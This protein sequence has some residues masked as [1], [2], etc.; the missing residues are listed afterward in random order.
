MAANLRTRHYD[1]AIILDDIAHVAERPLRRSSQRLNTFLLKTAAAEFLAVAGSAYVASAIY[2]FTTSLSLPPTDTYIAAAVSIATLVFMVSIALRQFI[3]IQSQPRHVVLWNG[4]VSV[5]LAFSLFLSCIFLLKLSDDYSRGSFLFQIAAVGIVVVTGRAISLS[6][7]RSAISTRNFEA[8][9]VVLIGETGMNLQFIG[10]LEEIGIKTVGSFSLP[11][12][13]DRRGGGTKEDLHR[14]KTIHEIV[15]KCRELQPDDIFVVAAQ[16]DLSMMTEFRRSFSEIPTGLH[17]ILPDAMEILPG[18]TIAQFGSVTAIQASRPPLNQFDLLV[19]RAFDIIAAAIGL[20]MLS[21]LFIIVSIAIKLGSRGPIFF[22]QLRHGYN[23]ET[24]NILKF[25]TMTTM[26]A[27]NEFTQAVKN[28]PRVTPFGRLLRRSNID[29][30]PQLINVLRGEMSV[31]GPRPHATVHNAMFMDKIRPF[32]RRRGGETGITG[33]AQVNGCRGETD[34]LEKMQRRIEHD[35]YYIDN[36]SFMLDL[37]V[38]ILTLFSKRA[39]LNA[40]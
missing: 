34:T 5:A 15:A 8:R 14:N 37:K 13:L 20:V 26:E 3:E 19:K 1:S 17:F 16:N 38:I 35:L 25:R 33:W 30:L 21:P 18:A 28:D 32:S 36:W 22:R 31:V 24:I 11:R 7:L 12:L 4:I 2:H 39:Y 29:E 40:Y 9:R 23:N 10:R 6:R 27:G